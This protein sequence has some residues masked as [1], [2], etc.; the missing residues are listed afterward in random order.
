MTDYTCKENSDCNQVNVTG[1]CEPSGYC[2]FSDSECDSGFR[3]GSASGESSRRCTESRDA[4][5]EEP[6]A[7]ANANADAGVPAPAI[8]KLSA[9]LNHTCILQENG[10]S[11]CWGDNSS[12]QLNEIPDA[13]H[14]GSAIPFSDGI[15]DA[16]GL[17][18]G[19]RSTCLFGEFGIECFGADDDSQ[20]SL[21]FIS[22]IDART[23]S[24]GKDHGASVCALGRDQGAIGPKETVYCWGGNGSGQATA[25]GTA[26]EDIDTPIQIETDVHSIAVGRLH[27]CALANSKIGDSLEVVCWGNNEFAQ[28]GTPVDSQANALD[29][30][31]LPDDVTPIK[32]AAG[33]EHNCIIDSSN[34]VHCWGANR[35][36]QIGQPTGDPIPVLTPLDISAE[37][38]TSAVEISLG[39]RHSCLLTEDR[40]VY[41][42]GDNAFGQLGTENDDGGP[43]SG[44]SNVDSIS[45]GQ[46]HSCAHVSDIGVYCW[47]RNDFNQVDTS[48]IGIIRQPVL[49]FAQP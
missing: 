29:R 41:C 39:S 1:R 46:Y 5:V 35:Y 9:G 34:Q 36:G 19:G 28:M 32:L 38:T 37:V 6:D 11:Q 45:V 43:V 15:G 7:N 48:T 23:V 20:L 8:I 31:R 49:S 27:A 14:D 25:N 12:G 44:L 4:G 22:E 17:G 24:I 40:K 33:H 42:W 26:S 30:V 16:I 3:F 13:D 2:S 18:A 21:G 10:I 47:G